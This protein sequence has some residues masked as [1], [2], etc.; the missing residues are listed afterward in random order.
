VTRLSLPVQGKL[1]R[2]IQFREFERVGGTATLSADVRII[3]ATY[4]D[5]PQMLAEG[6]FLPELLERL[7]VVQISMPP[8]RDRPEDIPALVEVFLEKY[9]WETKRSIKSIAPEALELLQRYSFPGNVRE[10]ENLIERA[11]ILCDTDTITPADLPF[12]ATSASTE[13]AV[14]EDYTHLPFKEAQKE[15]EKRY[16][17]AA[18]RKAKGVVKTAAELAGID[19]R[20]FHRK[21][22]EHGLDRREFIA[23]QP[24]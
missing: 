12:Q 11:V 5:L 13:V 4:Q 20:N 19:T 3:A 17:M 22:S 8:L 18:L 7:K 21:M 23:G 6:K 9:S 2:P 1:L 10:L 15:W 24:E 16:L 14:G